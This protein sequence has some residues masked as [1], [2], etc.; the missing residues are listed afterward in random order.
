V[1]KNPLYLK[2]RSVL[3]ITVDR[4]HEAARNFD[5]WCAKQQLGSAPTMQRDCGLIKSSEHLFFSGESISVGRCAGCDTKF[6][7]GISLARKD[8]PNLYSS[9]DGWKRASPEVAKD[10]GTGE[11]LLLL[12][13]ALLRE[14]SPKLK[15]MCRAVALILPIHFDG[16]FRPSEVLGLTPADVSTRSR[17]AGGVP[18]VIRAGP[19]AKE[20]SQLDAYRATLAIPCARPAKT[21]GR[22][23]TGSLLM[24]LGKAARKLDSSGKS[25][26]FVF[27][28]TDFEREVTKKF[29]SEVSG[30]P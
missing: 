22:G 15:E 11:A 3:P 4:Y 10:P 27:S 18:V 5:A 17:K 21:A 6:V 30:L 20:G 2:S 7:R 13:H 12:V 25:R 24:T 16:Y 19:D 23:W 28:L 9:P 14:K 8:Y 29:S 26:L 1:Q